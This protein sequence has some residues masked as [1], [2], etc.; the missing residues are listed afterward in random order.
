MPLHRLHHLV[1]LVRLPLFVLPALM[2]MLA[3]GWPLLGQAQVSDRVRTSQ[4]SARLLAHAPQGVLGDVVPTPGTSDSASGKAAGASGWRLPGSP[5]PLMDTPQPASAPSGTSLG[6]S[7]GT[8]TDAPSTV[9][10]E[11]A[12]PVWL[13]LL[14]QHSQGW[15]TYWK[16]PGDS[17]LPTQLSWQLPPG[18]EAAEVDWPT[19]EKIFVGEMANYGYEGEVLLPVRLR[20]TPDFRPQ[21]GQ[22]SLPVGLKA[23]W[24]VCQEECIPQSGEFR[25]DVPLRSSTALDGALFDAAWAA[26]PQTLSPGEHSLRLSADGKRLLLAL[27]GLPSNW[28]GKPLALMVETPNVVFNAARKV[29]AKAPLDEAHLGEQQWAEAWT[30]E[31]WTASYP[32]SD[33]RGDSPTHLALVVARGHTAW[34]AE[35]PVTGTWPATASVSPALAAALAAN[36]ND[37]RDAAHP[38]AQRPSTAPAAPTTSWLLAL[39]GALLGGLLLNLMP[40]VFPVLAIKLMGFAHNEGREGRQRTRASGLGYCIGVVAT[41]LALGGALLALRAA[42]QQLGWGFQLQS[43]WLVA[44]LATLFTLIALNLFGLFEVPTR[45]TNALPTQLRSHPLLDHV[46]AGVLAVV[47][48]SPCTAPFMGASVGLAIGLPAWQALGIFAAL[49]VGMALPVIAAMA[50]PGLGRLLPRSGGWMQS[51]RQFLAFP[52]LAT[53]VWL[54]WVLGQQIG[55]D[56]VTAF[57]ALLLCLTLVLWTLRLQ[58]KRAW[59]ATAASVLA[60]AWV[61]HWAW[62]QLSTPAPSQAT[63]ADAGGTGSDKAHSSQPGQPSQPDPWQT[64]SQTAVEQAVAKGKPVFVDYTAAWCVTCQFNKKT[65]L[66]DP[67]VLAAFA[68]RGV[69]LMRADWTRQD[70]AISASLQALG[71]SGVPV[72]VLHAPGQPPQVFTEILRADALHAALAGLPA[73]PAM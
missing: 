55:I 66:A 51:F 56:G 54:L 5:A 48:A 59:L 65:T 28:R 47:V 21:A 38:S 9:S 13:G 20:F 27:H 44:G 39:G 6:T 64:W 17:G 69:Q 57:L 53:V 46:Y 36:A 34:R 67:A 50:F 10:A 7:A 15:H 19:P 32:V 37:T 1:R 23:T 45:L 73:R 12:S 58:A 60:L 35:L 11:A 71:R 62:P 30:G 8:P 40:C 26:R 2:L 24:L 29:A 72:Y 41:C 31:V 49:G 61:G 68:Q 70:P 22:T 18:V 63:Q 43:P 25:L 4:V 14:L 33:L 52:M 3:L 42:G 16:N